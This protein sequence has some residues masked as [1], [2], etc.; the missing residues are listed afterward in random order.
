MSKCLQPYNIRYSRNMYKVSV[1]R[2][3]RKDISSWTSRG[4]EAGK[5]KQPPES[6]QEIEAPLCYAVGGMEEA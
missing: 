6:E 2:Y 4:T 1:P 5:Y 3:L